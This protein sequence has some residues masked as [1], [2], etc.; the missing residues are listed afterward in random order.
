MMEWIGL[1]ASVVI[2][3]KFWGFDDDNGGGGDDYG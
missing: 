3:C 2:A 1:M